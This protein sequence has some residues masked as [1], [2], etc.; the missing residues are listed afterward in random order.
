MSRVTTE[1]VG[2]SSSPR[3]TVLKLSDRRYPGVLIQGDRLSILSDLSQR[4][5]RRLGQAEMDS[6]EAEELGAMAGELASLLEEHLAEFEAV[7]NAEG[8]EL[9]YN[10]DIDFDE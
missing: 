2:F 6:V 3:R 7:L 9:P 4:L 1:V 8:I 10:R 5:S